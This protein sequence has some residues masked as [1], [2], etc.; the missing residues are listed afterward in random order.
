M[1]PAAFLALVLALALAGC[2]TTSEPR[3]EVRTVEVPVRVPC[4]TNLG[5]APT[6]VDTD[7]AFAAAADIF[8]QAKL[9]LA[10]R[11]QRDARLAEQDAALAGCSR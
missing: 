8:E 7:P 3:I 5:P 10:G 6:Y 4:A 2:A 11:K 9:L 1:K